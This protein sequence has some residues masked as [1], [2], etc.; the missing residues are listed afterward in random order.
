MSIQEK[1]MAPGTFTVSLSGTITPNSV[2]NSIDPWGQILIHSTRVDENTIS[3]QDMIKT[4]RYVGVVTNLEYDLDSFQ[5]SGKGT[6]IYLGDTDSRGLV[7]AETSGSGAVRSYTNDSFSDVLDRSTSTPFG[8][9]RTGDSAAQQAVRTKSGSITNPTSGTTTYTGDHYLEST[10][11]AVKYVAEHFECEFFV[12]NEGF[13]FAGRPE[14]LFNGHNNDPDAII[15]RQGQGEDPNIEGFIPAGITTGFNAEEY[16]SKVELIPTGETKEVS[17]ADATVSVNQFKDLHNQNLKRIQVVKDASATQSNFQARANKALSEYNRLKKTVNVSLEG[18]DISGSFKVGDKIFIYD[19]DVGFEDTS[20]KAALES[21]D[22]HQVTYQ[23][24]TINPEKIRVVGMSYPVQE[25]MGV[26]YRNSSTGVITDLTDYIIFESGDISLEIGDVGQTLSTDFSTAASVIAVDVTDDFTVPDQPTKPSNGSVGFDHSVGTYRDGAGAV[27]GFIKLDWT[28]PQ[29]KN[30]TT[31][32]D[33]S[34]FLIQWRMVS[35]RDGNSILDSNDV[36]LDTSDYQSA[37]VD[38]DQSRYIIENLNI[39]FT[40]TVRLF[41][42]DIKNHSSDVVQVAAIQIPRS[43]IAPNKPAKPENTFGSLASGLLRAQIVHKLA[44]VKDDDGNAINSP[45]NFTLDRDISHLNVYGAKSTF[46]LSYDSTNKKIADSDRDT[47][48]LG[49]LPASNGNI[50]LNIPVVGTVNLDALNLTSNDTVYYR[51]T[52]VNISGRESEPSDVFDSGGANNLIDTQHIKTAAITT[53]LIGTAQITDAEVANMNVNKLVS[54]SISG[55]TITLA[56]DS[57]T[58][59]S[60]KSSNF[61]SGSAGFEIKSN[62]DVEFNDGNFR[63]D[64]TG[65][66]GTFSGSLSS[67]VSI[68]APTISGGSVSGT[69]ISGGTID[70]GGSDSTSFHV[71][72]DGNMFLGAASIGSAPFKVTKEGALTATSV[73]ASDVFVSGVAITPSSTTSAVNMDDTS[74]LTSNFTASGSG[75]FRTASS[76]ARVEIASNFGPEIRFFNS[77]GAD[78]GRIGDDGTGVLVF[79][80]GVSNDMF[81]HSLD[82]LHIS[83]TNTINFGSIIGG[84]GNPTIKVAGSGGNNKFLA[85]DGSGRLTLTGNTSSSGV[86]SITASGELSLTGA[87]TGD[88]T[89]THAASDHNSENDS[90]YYSAS[91]GAVLA[92]SLSSHTGHA[93]ALSL[94]SN[95]S[96]NNSGGLFVTAVS[97]LG[98]TRTNIA[99]TTMDTQKVRP[100]Q[101][102]AYALGESGRKYTIVHSQFGVTSSSDQRL[103]ENIEDLSLGLDFINKLKPKKYNWTTETITLDSGEQ[104]VKREDMANMDMFGFLAQDL[105][106]I[107]DLDNST[108]YGLVRYDEVE[109]SYEVSNDNYIAPLVKAVQELS[110]QVSDLTARIEALEG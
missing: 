69:S 102:E 13:I 1:V 42:F 35:D 22:I 21:R 101:T 87:G 66:S 25:G 84:S 61:S 73:T 79:R 64:I 78:V 53:A 75:K 20:S 86:D 37:S 97:G 105:L 94:N 74:T 41:A 27:K 19:P 95:V 48:Y 93:T 9:L 70:I 4:A 109:D 38:F 85:T 55:K 52:A 77:S 24:S 44:Q 63:G 106:E 110:T 30:G 103:K 90:R 28:K 43:S 96:N 3:N 10:F 11:R 14:V 71:D 88:V 91:A 58:Q 7:V 100:R 60:I 92:S 68:T 17:M 12:D 72:S 23:G 26:Y 67:G 2:I 8:L 51:V 108:T 47:Y 65:A 81:I 76:G 45:I 54:G 104:I 18:Y 59:S 6:M 80:T 5:V 83:A 33:G 34:H 31:I 46:S 15:I 82:E 39:G 29:N 107:D 57:G 36:A 16:V 98:I 40:Y 56:A 32:L 99:G 50:D 62:G 49:M 89:I